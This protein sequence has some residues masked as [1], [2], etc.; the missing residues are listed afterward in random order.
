MIH[1]LCVV[2]PKLLTPA[3]LVFLSEGLNPAIPKAVNLILFLG[4]LYYLLRKPT[5]DFF[6]TRLVEVRGTLDRAGRDRDEALAKL[7]QIDTRLSQ[8]DAELA[9]IKAQADRETEAEQ[10]R[11]ETEATADVERLRRVAH[12]EIEAAKQGALAELRKF[13]AEKSVALAE[14]LI[15]R[16]LT[17]EDD[18]RLVEAGAQFEK[19]GKEVS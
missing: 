7:S 12:R 19:T 14:Q 18:R 5:R 6:K 3:F 11:L 1:S 4:V 15:K 17:S 16:E 10:T 2:T 9:D 8:L 13:T